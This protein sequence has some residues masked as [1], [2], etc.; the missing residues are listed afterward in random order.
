[1]AEDKNERDLDFKRDG[2]SFDEDPLKFCQTIYDEAAERADTLG[3]INVDNMAFYEG[4]DSNL[5]ARKENAKVKRSAIYVHE[6]TPAVDTRVGAPIAK[7]EEQKVPV[8]VKPRNQN[9]TEEEKAQALEIE[10]SL[11]QQLRAAGYL[12]DIF[13]E[14]ALAAEIQRSPS[15]VKVGWNNDT[16]EVPVKKMLPK[17]EALGALLGGRSPVQVVWEKRDI[18]APYVEW[19]HPEDILYEPGCSS[20]DDGKYLIHRMWLEKH[21]IMAMAREFDFDEKVMREFNTMS[22]NPEEPGDYSSNN[23]QRDEIEDER[24]TSF[25]DTYRDGK[26]LVTEN[27]IVHYDDDGQK[28]VTRCWVLGNKLLAKKE[29]SP[30]RGMT[31]PAVALVMNRI[32]GT[33]EGLSSIDRGKH[34]QMLYN[35]LYNAYVDWMTYGMFSPL[36][37][38]MGFSFEGTPVFGPGEIWKCSEPD[39]LTPVLQANGRAPATPAL[40]ESIAAKIQ[41]LVGAMDLSQGFQ[42]QAYEKAT[43]TKARMM[44]AERRSVPNNKEYGRAIIRVAEMFLRLN[45]IY[46]PEKEKYVLDVVIDVPSLTAATD[47]E[48]EKQEMLLLLAQ[49]LQNPI[50][51]TPNGQRKIRNL[52]EALMVKFLRRDV[53]D[54]VPTREEHDRDI[55]LQADMEAAMLEKQNAAEQLQLTAQSAAQSQEQNNE[56]PVQ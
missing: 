18:G 37:A 52:M 50:Y 7:I 5:K 46:S 15:I 11:N 43:S 6:L 21:E 9:P 27:F 25:R 45:Q 16:E 32:P 36:K 42:S 40:L 31:F 20:V 12:T 35:E 1:M 51:Q 34:L 29:P 28:T 49:A 54:F 22:D 33:T 41:Q 55:G 44:G 17:W 39:E 3:P 2:V 38:P 24:G 23:S 30:Y 56:V 19:M 47:P 4:I 48:T 26:Y 53:D 8:S 14:H 13:R 10:F